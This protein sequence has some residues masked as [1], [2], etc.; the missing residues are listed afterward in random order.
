MS[1][2]FKDQLKQASANLQNINATLQ[3]ISALIEAG[4]INVS[5][6]TEGVENPNSISLNGEI[7]GSV[8][9][10]VISTLN[11][12]KENTLAIKEQ[13]LAA[14]ESEVMEEDTPPV[15]D[16]VDEI[17]VDDKPEKPDKPS[18]PKK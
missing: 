8:L 1:Q 14:L 2:E 12:R 17:T 13:I 4:K 18:K 3:T 5:D 7:V 9:R 15:G 6:A 11:R 10:P 16:P